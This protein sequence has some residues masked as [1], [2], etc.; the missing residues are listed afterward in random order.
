MITDRGKIRVNPGVEYITDW[1]D[2]KG[3]YMIDPYV[4]SGRIIVNKMVTGCGFTSYCL[5]NKYDT[6]LLSPR[7]RLIQNKLE[8]VN[9]G[10][11]WCFYYNRERDK[12]GKELFSCHEL[13]VKL[14]SYVQDRKQ[15]GQPLKILVTYDSFCKLADMLEASLSCPVSATFRIVVDE[16]HSLIKDVKLKEYSNKNVLSQLV[17][18][19]FCYERVLFISAT[20]IIDYISQIPEFYNNDVF[21]YELEWSNVNPVYQRKHNCRSAID[22]FHQIYERYQRNGMFDVRHVNSNEFTSDQAVIFLNSVEDIAKILKKYKD[23]IDA[24]DVTIICAD[25]KENTKKLQGVSSKY[26]IASSIPKMGEPH[27]TWTFVTRTAFEGVDFYS[28]CASTFVIANYYVPSLCLDIASDIPQIVGRQ[29][30]KDN[31]FR[32]TIH[33]YYV[34]NVRTVDGQEFDSYQQT[35]MQTSNDQIEIWNGIN[36][37]ELQKVHLD[38]VALRIEKDDVYLTTANGKPEINHLLIQSER[39]CLDILRKQQCWFISPYYSHPRCSNDV[40]G[41]MTALGSISSGNVTEDR[42]KN[43]HV[44]LQSH[45]SLENEV[46]VMLQAEGYDDI[47]YYLNSLTLERI[48]ACAYRTNNMKLEISNRK[49]QGG[50][51]EIVASAFVKGRVYSKKEV[52]E[53]LQ[54]IYNQQGIKATAKA[55]DLSNYMECRSAKKNGL[56]AMLI[57]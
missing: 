30:R 21:Y 52:K 40:H 22:A 1:T 41:L 36:N 39:Y 12:N 25:N 13:E 17:N 7:L 44:F 55:T 32:D 5:S 43:I 57:I 4:S 53:T 11:E 45:P 3:E 26:K 42:L 37:P 51:E 19:L 8:Q 47:L 20:P 6:I 34:K 50:I 10:C 15:N 54:Q 49:R 33:I 27:T 24:R 46:K 14:R 2:G 56:H 9:V 38:N 48:K 35:K 29:R 28:P 16:S 31:L 18:R 23:H